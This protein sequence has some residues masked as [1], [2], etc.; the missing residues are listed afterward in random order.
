[1]KFIPLVFVG[2]TKSIIARLQERINFAGETSIAFAISV[3]NHYLE[4]LR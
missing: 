3:I 1:M 2:C 4:K